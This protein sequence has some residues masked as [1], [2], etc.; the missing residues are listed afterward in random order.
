METLFLQVLKMSVT[1]SYVILFVILARL[2]LRK[3]PRIFSYALWPVALFRLVCPF[4]FES[5]FSF[6]PAVLTSPSTNIMPQEAPYALVPQAQGGMIAAGQTAQT[7]HGLWSA[8]PA[9]GV[10]ASPLQAWITWGEAIWLLGLVLLLT[11]SIYTATR[12]YRQLGSAEPIIGNI[13]EMKGL[14]TPFVFGLLRPKI[15]LPA[16]L[17]EKEKGYIIKHE[18]THIQ[19]FDHLIK[20]LAFLVLCVH[21]FNP[22]VWLA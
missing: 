5:F 3:A 22:L 19:R 6:I 4:S 16:G 21:W 15:Y 8:F 17:A 7:A 12:L 11:Y 1:S 18:Q 10:A 2:L 9:A 13:H 20:P 14:K